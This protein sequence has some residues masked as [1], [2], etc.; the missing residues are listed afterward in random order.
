MI[1]RPGNKCNTQSQS[2]NASC[3]RIFCFDKQ[4][5]GPMS[6]QAR[7]LI[8]GNF[9]QTWQHLK[10]KDTDTELYGEHL[11]KAISMHNSPLMTISLSSLQKRFKGSPLIFKLS[12]ISALC[13]F[14]FHFSLQGEGVEVSWDF[15]VKRFSF[16]AISQSS[17]TSNLSMNRCFQRTSLN[18][19]M[20]CFSSWYG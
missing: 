20:E 4:R 15:L 11:L 16:R 3:A 13:V 2:C 18:K 10:T 14:V 5:I 1:S 7:K 12:F 17:L 9:K 8:H 6:E 19:C